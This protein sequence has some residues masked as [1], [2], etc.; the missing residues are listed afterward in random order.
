MLK[1]ESSRQTNVVG[2]AK[3]ALASI[4]GIGLLRSGVAEYAGYRQLASYDD[5]RIH[6]V[7]QPGAAEYYFDD[8]AVNSGDSRPSLASGLTEPRTDLRPMPEDYR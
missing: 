6:N 4:V 2:L 7:L 3:L 5:G 8:S 1:I